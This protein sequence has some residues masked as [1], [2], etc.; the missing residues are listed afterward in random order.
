MSSFFTTLNVVL[1]ICLMVGLGV[2][3]RA[4]RIL[5]DG[6]CAALN[7][8]A[9]NALLPCMIFTNIYTGAAQE[10][11]YGKLLLFAGLGFIAAYL[12][13]MLVVPRF[14]KT[15]AK[16]GVI[17]QGCTHNS[18]LIIG[19]GLAANLYPGMDYAVMGVLAALAIP[20]NHITS[21]LALQIFQDR[22]YR[23]RELFLQL[24]KNPL[25]LASLLAIFANAVSLP[26]PKVLL[27][28]MTTLGGAAVP[29]CLLALGGGFRFSSLSNDRWQVAFACVVKLLLLPLCFL[30]LAVLL[31]F[32]GLPLLSLLVF[33]GTPTAPVTYT[34]SASMGG[35]AGLTSR[36]VLFSNCFAAITLF[37]FIDVLLSMG[38]L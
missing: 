18:F 22:K 15:P 20:I 7:G 32:Q 9:F 23:L 34:L 30:P 27:S 37:G 24:A 17:V 29:I 28:A 4:G 12:F 11:G 19:M 3:L 16:R 8:T 14:E 2:L 26:L 5:D 31:G 33:F 36:V 25:L 1:P 35:D 38:F 13:L 6:C 10:A 21:V